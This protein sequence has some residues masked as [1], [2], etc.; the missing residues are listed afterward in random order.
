VI[1]AAFDCG[2]AIEINSHP[3][4][5][6]LDWRWVKLAK[7]KGVRIFINPDAHNVEGSSHVQYR[8]GI[9][10]KGWLEAN[11]V[12]NAWPSRKVEKYLQ[13]VRR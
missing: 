3:S 13:D 5:L 11:D 9:V 6:D 4:R 10:R 2:K 12:V 8:I 1:Q 7:G